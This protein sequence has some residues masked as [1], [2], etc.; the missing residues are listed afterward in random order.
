[1]SSLFWVGLVVDQ[2]VRL[3]SQMEDSGVK[4]NSYTCIMAIT[5]I[6]AEKNWEQL[7][8][9]FAIMQR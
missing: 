3:L 1:M 9:I 2:V 7:P 6:L 5:V 4:P 8:D